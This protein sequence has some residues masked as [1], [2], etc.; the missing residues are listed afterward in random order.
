MT[1]SIDFVWLI[2]IIPFCGALFIG[3]LLLSFTRTM[4]RLSKPV[5]FILFSSVGLS[6][7]ISYFFLSSELSQEVMRESYFDWQTPFFDQNIHVG[8]LIDKFSSIALSIISTMVLLSM[9]VFQKVMFRKKGYV[10]YFVYLVLISSSILALPI[11]TFA[12]NSISNLIS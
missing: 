8:L 4:N 6:A 9:F 10:L 1:A 12:R 3:V 2:P 11:N 7:L 5:S